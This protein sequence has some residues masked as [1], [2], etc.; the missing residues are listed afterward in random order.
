[1]ATE[2]PSLIKTIVGCADTDGGLMAMNRVVTSNPIIYLGFRLH[3]LNL[4][5]TVLLHNMLLVV[6][7]GEDRDF[8]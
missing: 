6:C 5:N 8:N 2:I 4:F 7:I 3:E 1:M